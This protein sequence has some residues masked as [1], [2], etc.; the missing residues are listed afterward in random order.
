MET[1][2]E[3]TAKNQ[4]NAARDFLRQA[5]GSEKVKDDEHVLVSYATDYRRTWFAKPHM[6][7]LP[8]SK[9]D[10]Q[11]ILKTANKYKIPVTVQARGNHS[12]F[13]I[14]SEGGIVLDC[15]R[16][17]KIIEINTDSGYALI[18]IG[19]T[20]DDFTAALRE[21]GFR[22]H[23]P[24]A[25]GGATPVGNYLLKP[26]GSL[27]TR[28]LDTIQSLEVVLPDGTVFTTGSAAYPGV[29]SH[30]RYGPYPDLCGLITMA[31]GTLGVVT[32]AAIKI[33]P[34]NE[35]T[36]VALVEIDNFPSAVDFV[37]DITDHNIPEHSIIWFHQ[38][39]QL[40]GCDQS[41]PLP[42][43]LH[44][45]PRKAPPGLLIHLSA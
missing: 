14:P 11:V 35:C 9:E 16:M 5:I 12:Q 42:A 31:Y 21:K 41:K 3:V 22:C 1:T 10:V 6:V 27:A 4:T 38:L 44:A 13:S 30:L 37:K 40:F 20:F 8:E 34:I 18:E 26:A 24:T 19:V 23:V 28:H 15:R 39:H 32:K 29:G 43:E 33:Y 25:P 7:V 45:D 2:N 17:D 36:R